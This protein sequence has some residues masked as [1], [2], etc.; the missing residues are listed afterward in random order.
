MQFIRLRKP[1]DIAEEVFPELG[2]DC[3]DTESVK[4]I[5][6]IVIQLVGVDM[7]VS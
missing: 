6:M 2:V 4:S 1:I 3:V 5:N 7:L